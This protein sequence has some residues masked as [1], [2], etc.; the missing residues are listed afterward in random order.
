MFIDDE[1]TD[2][3]TEDA[4]QQTGTKDGE[5][6]KEPRI[7]YKKDDFFDNISCEALERSKGYVRNKFNIEFPFHQSISIL[8]VSK[9]IF[10]FC[11]LRNVPRVDWKAERKLNA[12]TFGLNPNNSNVG[13]ITRINRRGMGNGQ[14]M[15][16]RGGNMSRGSGSWMIMPPNNY[17]R[18][19]NRR[20]MIN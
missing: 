11:V 7:F 6:N 5:E 20:Q 12:E 18:G 19:G 1:G 4:D 8:F 13:G 9:N 16:S 2:N 10:L 14:G 15:M 17:F 3:K